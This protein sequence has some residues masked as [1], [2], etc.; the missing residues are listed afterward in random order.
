MISSNFQIITISHIY[1][2]WPTKLGL[3]GSLSGGSRGFTV[4]YPGIA[5]SRQVSE[6]GRVTVIIKLDQLA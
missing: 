3:L 1:C 4:R 6:F 2:G 5:K